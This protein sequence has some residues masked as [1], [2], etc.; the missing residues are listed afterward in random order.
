MKK[1]LFFLMLM[2]TVSITAQNS[3]IVH[4]QT[5]KHQD[6][7]KQ[8]PAT[9]ESSQLSHKLSAMQQKLQ[10]DRKK[11]SQSKDTAVPPKIKQAKMAGISW[12]D[13]GT[14]NSWTETIEFDPANEELIPIQFMDEYGNTIN[15]F[16]YAVQFT[17]EQD[18]LVTAMS[19]SGK[20]DFTIYSDSEAQQEVAWN[21]GLLQ[22]LK[23]GVYYL[24]ISDSGYL[25]W[26][27][28]FQA[29]IELHAAPTTNISLPYQESVSITQE[30]S[31]L[32]ANIFHTVFY[33][34]T[35]SE[36]A[37]VNL[38][39]SWDEEAMGEYFSYFELDLVTENYMIYASNSDIPLKAGTYYLAAYGIMW[40]DEA[41]WAEH[42]SLEA[43]LDIKTKTLDAPGVLSVPYE[44]DFSMATNNAYNL[45]D[46]KSL[47]YS[48]HLDGTQI[49][50]INPG[51]QWA[52]FI[53][54]K[55]TW[56]LIQGFYPGQTAI[57]QLKA[58]DYYM[59]IVDYNRLYDGETPVNGH[60][61]I[62]IPLS[63]A[64]LDFSE[65]IA[66]GETKI[67]DDASLISVITDIGGMMGVER[68]KVAAY[69]FNVQA[70]HIYKLVMEC[71]AKT[72]PMQ[73]TLALFRAPNTGDIYADN[74]RGAM[75][76]INATS[77]TGSLTWQ[78][79]FNGDVNVM[80]FFER[81]ESDV[82]FNLTLEEIEATHTDAP[83]TTPAY[84]DITLPFVSWLHFDPAYNAYWNESTSE[85]HKLYRLTL[86]EKTELKIDA[87]FNRK[88]GSSMYLKIFTDENRTQP[89]GDPWGYGEGNSLLLD[90]GTYYL[91]MSDYE[92]FKYNE[93]YAECLVELNGNTDFDEIPTVT[94]AQLMD[95][96][97][98][99][100][101]SYFDN[102]SYT[103]QG[104]FVYGTSKLV[105]DPNF[106][107]SYLFVKGYKL[108]GMNVGD[109][110]HVVDRQPANEYESWLSIYKKEDNGSYRQLAEN[111]SDWD[112]PFFGT[113]HIKFTA[114]EA[115]DYYI[116]ASTSNSYPGVYS[117]VEYPS[118]QVGIWKE[119]ATG[120][121]QLPDEVIIASTAAN[122]TE[123]NVSADASSIDVK[124]ALMALEVT[125]TTQAG[126]TVV[127]ENNPMSWEVNDLVTEASF[128]V[129]PRPYLVAETY[130]PATVQI[131]SGMGI[132]SAAPETI[133]IINSGNGLFTI[134]GLQGKEAISLIDINGRVLRKTTAQG[135]TATIEANVLP[136][137]VYIVAVQN[138]KKLTVLKFIK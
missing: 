100:V 138:S 17:L 86:P 137:G 135:V 90:A 41:F 115:C 134:T 70:G 31:I 76:Y 45:F 47:L 66:V 84:E 35:L 114:T 107:I 27:D 81:P 79:D 83:G 4:P 42:S 8:K 34:F 59:T 132:N 129:I 49:I 39:S 131:K 60:L 127:L 109:E 19:S 101:I 23:A 122:V 25:E 10:A 21:Y 30:N 36:D 68:K 53:Y 32:I 106:Y 62:R 128:V 9:N 14:L 77:G 44:Q 11:V 3:F 103:D 56:N 6:G 104:Y 18:E 15:T 72:S 91:A 112:A 26:T 108:T 130:N 43:Q 121:L 65:T 33:K 37:I 85:Y 96:P 69:H 111:S 94:V 74:I 71:Y 5:L 38:G 97:A 46:Y 93:E 78:A 102:L 54:D 13:I 116:M 118:Y 57:V 73:P 51:D 82:M 1:A 123:V 7:S 80:F 110:V 55:E 48:L 64:T 24:L 20:N 105:N 119:P 88:Q 124:L 67:G 126:T 117:N 120:D 87:G 98:I 92:Y 58:G 99:P 2:L 12:A 113:T 29:S 52:L 61:S 136:N 22:P 133:R 28:P 125:A 75:P 63:Y 40:D 89:V 95:D 50:E 16:C